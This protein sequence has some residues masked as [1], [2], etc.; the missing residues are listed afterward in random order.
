MPTLEWIGK[1]KVINHH[2]EVPFRVLERKYSFDESGQHEEDNG[3][4]NMIIR[5]DNLEALK[6]LLPRYEGRVKCIYIDPPY[7]TGNEGWVYNDNVNDPKIKKWLGEVVG[8]EGE[9]LTRHDK[10]LC[11]MY[12]RLKLLQKLLADDGV[13]FISIDTNELYNLKSIC[14]EIFGTNCFVEDISWQRTY[15]MRNDVKGIAAEVEHIL[16]YGKKPFWQPNKLPRTEQMDSKYKNPDNDPRGAWRNIVASA[17]NAATHQGMVYAIQNPT[18]G[19]YAYPPQGRCWS[20]GQEQMLEA[21]NKWCEYRL[22]D[23]GDSAKRAE[24]CGVSLDAIRK[25]VLAIVLAEPL[26]NAKGKA[27]AIFE[28]GVLPEFYFSRNGLGTLSRKAYINEVG[29]RPVTNL[30]SFEE[31]GHTDEASRL[32]KTIFNGTVVFDTPKPPR[33]LERVLHIAGD[34]QTLI[35]DS[36]AGSGTTAHAVL[37]MNK[38]DGGKRKFILVEMMDY[39]DS[40]T[41]ERVKRVIGGYGEGKKAVEGTGGSF[42]FYDLGEPLLIGDCLNEAVGTEK[43]REYIWFTETKR[44]YAPPRGGNPY[45]LG[46]NNH[47]GYY[48]YYEPDRMTVLDYAFLS[49][50]TEKT[51]GAVIYADRCA[52]SQDKLVEMEIMFKKIPRDISRL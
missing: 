31:T 12:P 42:S 35:L 16:V 11:M 33:L 8:K 28:H 7:N 37:N 6:A 44:P 46:Q 26:E 27:K 34:N 19:E 22:T 51:D 30:W 20:L 47:T 9:D 21:M 4:E 15:S 2:Q 49:T 48:F 29:G 38:A 23:L 45:Y 13:I 18:T 36:F 50:I 25:D 1:D 14:D 40:I 39:A 52:I 43:I 5:G 10:W 17:P 24:M 3:S 41:A 32:L